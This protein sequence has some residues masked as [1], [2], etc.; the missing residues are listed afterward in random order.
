[1]RFVRK[2]LEGV[3]VFYVTPNIH[4]LTRQPS[5]CPKTYVEYVE[6]VRFL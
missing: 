5:Y 4:V 2:H 1:V 3:A 6:N